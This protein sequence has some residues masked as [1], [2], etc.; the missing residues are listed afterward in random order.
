MTATK[1]AIVTMTVGEPYEQM[2]GG[3]FRDGWARYALRHGYDLLSIRRPLRADP[4]GRSVHWQKLLICSHPRFADYD[5]LV[6][7]DADIAINAELAPSIVDDVPEDRIGIVLYGDLQD[8]EL[9]ELV[10]AR[11]VAAFR[12][13]RGRDHTGFWET[14]FAR[15]GLSS[16]PDRRF[17]TGVL[18]L[19]PRLHAGLLEEVFAQHPNDAFDKEQTFLNHA[20]LSAD[21][22]HPLDPRFNREVGYELLKHYPF[23]FLLDDERQRLGPSPAFDRLATAALATVWERSFFLHFPGSRWPQE[24]WRQIA[25]RPGAPDWRRMLAELLSPSGAAGS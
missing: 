22:A 4:F 12:A 6:W 10:K 24:I 18:V 15:E 7:V 2:W 17:N 13:A 23:L 1:K 19:T 11:W 21:L 5:R 14:Y 8:P 3:L 9:T 20:I 25:G 16:P